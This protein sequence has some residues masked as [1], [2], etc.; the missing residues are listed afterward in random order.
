MNDVA[1]AQLLGRFTSCTCL[2]VC[3]ALCFAADPF[4]TSRAVA[5]SPLESFSLDQPPELHLNV[6][7]DTPL[8]R[9]K[10]GGD[11]TKALQWSLDHAH[12][13]QQVLQIPAGRWGISETITTPYRSGLVLHGAGVIDAKANQAHAGMGSVLE[14]RGDQQ[15]V[16][17]RYRG[18]DGDVGNFTLDGRGKAEVGLLVER[19][20][21][22][23]GLG[24]GKTLFRPLWVHGLKYGLQF[25]TH[26]EGLNCDECEFE[27]VHGEKCQAV[28][29]SVTKQAMGIKINRLRN[30]YNPVGILAE[31]GGHWIVENSL[32][33]HPST[34]LRI[35]NS[36]QGFG[37]NNAFFRLS[38]TKVD[39]Q[40]ANGFTLV[41]CDDPAEIRILADGGIHS[42][43][44]FD[45]TFAKL[46]GSNFLHVTDFSSTFYRIEAKRHGGWGTPAVLLEACRIWG[47]RD[48]S[49]LFTGQVNARVVNCTRTNGTWLDWDSQRHSEPRQD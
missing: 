4:G 11:I 5:Q 19:P 13:H 43:T 30:Y 27:L 8:G 2:A 44:S 18:T 31:G 3:A 14:W 21:D 29:R 26:T 24:T 10:R 12:E 45:G 35:P 46:T 49:Q 9:I 17:I 28:F 38:N 37:P 41:D 47:E 1:R 6:C 48:V 16:M 25:G 22:A 40:A 34:L 36:K 20:N 39:A 32:T 42:G 23:Q 7:A 33:V 15:G